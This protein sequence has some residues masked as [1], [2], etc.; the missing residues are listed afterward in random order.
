MDRTFPFIVG[1]DVASGGRT[2]T[3]PLLTKV[4]PPPTAEFSAIATAGMV[5]DAAR[6]AAN[7]RDTMV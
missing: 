5:A 7:S 2:P 6:A 3:R 1:R 4:R